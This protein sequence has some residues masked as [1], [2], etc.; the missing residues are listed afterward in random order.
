MAPKTVMKSFPL[1]QNTSRSTRKEETEDAVR[2]W[3]DFYDEQLEA[4]IRANID[5]RALREANVNN[6]YDLCQEGRDHRKC[7]TRRM[8]EWRGVRHDQI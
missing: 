8:A 5:T 3:Y 2:R 4:A 7:E 1:S 6:G